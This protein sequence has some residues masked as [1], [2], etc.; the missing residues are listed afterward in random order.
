[1]PDTLDLTGA[2]SM[3][4]LSPGGLEE[5]ARRGEVPAAKIGKRWVFSR[6]LLLDWLAEETARQMAARRQPRASANRKTPPDLSRYG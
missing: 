2:A 6:A 1:M 4:F 5:L 3:L